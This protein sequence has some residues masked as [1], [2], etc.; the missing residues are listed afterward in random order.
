MD[1]SDWV[2]IFFLFLF[3]ICLQVV[4][5]YLTG[6]ARHVAGF[7]I[8]LSFVGLLVLMNAV[9]QYRAAP[10]PYI[11]AVVRPHNRIIHLFIKP[12]SVEKSGLLDVPVGENT[13][14]S[15]FELW[16]PVKFPGYRDKSRWVNIIHQYPL[17]QRLKFAPGLAYYEGMQ[18]KHGQVAHVVLY[19]YGMG[20]VDRAE[21]IPTYWL[22]EA[23][24]DIQLPSISILV[25]AHGNPTIPLD[26]QEMLTTIEKL[27][28][29]LTDAT[30]RARE[31]QQRD[32]RSQE[33]IIQLRNQLVALLK[34]GS[35]IVKGSIALFLYFLRAEQSIEGG[36]R[37]L[38]GRRFTLQ[39]WMVI[40][41]VACVLG[42]ALIIK[43]YL[44]QMILSWVSANAI[45]VVILLALALLG[46]Y[47]YGRRRK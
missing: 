17:A 35:D 9:Y 46:G 22:K 40:P 30:R 12:A 41:A 45:L 13:F 21:A 16:Q 24:G 37:A 27:K 6:V 3:P 14:S 31:Y 25:D 36:L 11:R 15:T 39:K 23:P 33:T 34:S 4:D 10:Y 5:I 2:F 28:I 47:E 32:L 7:F 42:L 38:R 44:A 19:D 43:P 26:Y 20:D 29:R 1:K 8:S 18:I